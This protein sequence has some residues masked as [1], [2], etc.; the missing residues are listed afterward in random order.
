MVCPHPQRRRRELPQPRHVGE[1]P[2][3]PVVVRH[4]AAPLRGGDRRPRRRG[5]VQ[6][7]VSPRALRAIPRRIRPAPSLRPRAT[8]L[9][10]GGT[11]PRRVRRVPGSPRRSRRGRHA[12]L[13]PRREPRRRARVRPRELERRPDD[14]ASASSPRGPGGR[15]GGRLAMV[16]RRTRARRVDP[17]RPPRVRRRTAHRPPTPQTS[18]RRRPRHHR[19]IRRRKRP[20]RPNPRACR[21]SRVSHRGRAARLAARGGHP[22]RPDA[23]AASG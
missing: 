8:R 4:A 3:A 15:R 21:E 7:H 5:G 9:P 16:P 6:R 14:I 19:E 1:S 23:F 12:P 22:R 11:H 13:L 17:R 20:K 18:A 2:R 10:R